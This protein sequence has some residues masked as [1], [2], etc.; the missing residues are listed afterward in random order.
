M[1]NG[2]SG[3]RKNIDEIWQTMSAPQ[4]DDVLAEVRRR[5]FEINDSWRLIVAKELEH[6]RGKANLVVVD[7]HS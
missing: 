3:D 1:A 5:D 2:G 6:L 4:R 7:Y